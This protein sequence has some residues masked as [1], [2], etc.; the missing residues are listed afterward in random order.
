LAIAFLVGALI[1]AGAVIVG[2]NTISGSLAGGI[3]AK[4]TTQPTAQPTASGNGAGT[5]ISVQ[6]KVARGDANAPVTIIEFS[7][8]QCPYCGTVEPTIEQVMTDYAGKVKLYFKNFPLSF[9]EF[10]QKAAEAAECAGDQG[11]YW[12]MHDQLFAD[13]S[14]LAVSDLKGYAQKLG[15][16]T[17]KFNSCLDTG[18]KASVVE[19]DFNDGSANG[20]S[21]TPAFFINGKMIVGAQPYS[22]FKTA[23]D[24]ALAG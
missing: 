8:F 6:G 24:A 12:E 1:I 5:Q 14:A 15:L 16:D 20:V 23:I 3:V 17:A 4:A 2:S 10:A 19:A 13:Q 22:A 21:G 9:H 11:K 18:A 7:D